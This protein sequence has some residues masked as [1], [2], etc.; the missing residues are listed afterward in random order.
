MNVLTVNNVSVSFVRQMQDKNLPDS[1]DIATKLFC[2]FYGKLVDA[3]PES[4]K[5]GH[6]DILGYHDA[7]NEAAVK[8]TA[9]AF[10]T[11]GRELTEEARRAVGEQFDY[12]SNLV[13]QQW[14]TVFRNKEERLV[15]KT[16]GMMVLLQRLNHSAIGVLNTLMD[17]LISRDINYADTWNS[18]DKDQ[19]DYTKYPLTVALKKI[20]HCDLP[21]A[22]SNLRKLEVA[23]LPRQM[24]SMTRKNDFVS[25]V[26][27]WPYLEGKKG[28]AGKHLV[29]REE[30]EW[31]AL[32]VGGPEFVQALYPY[33]AYTSEERALKRISGHLVA[34]NFLS[35]THKEE[36]EA[37]GAL[38]DKSVWEEGGSL[39]P[40]PQYS[41]FYQRPKD[42]K[43]TPAEKPSVILHYV[44]L[45]VAKLGM[46]KQRIEKEETGKILARI[47][48]HNAEVAAGAKLSSGE[49]GAI[50]T[51]TDDDDQ[52]INLK[53][54][55][56]RLS[57]VP[58]E[59]V[60]T[61]KPTLE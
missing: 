1:A 40:L 48:A 21:K 37:N 54:K 22:Q 18:W 33:G 41:R 45:A 49:A 42:K 36:I 7:S 47:E 52:Q 13:Q 56:R 32:C 4:A 25:Y 50:N 57:P 44:N 34:F 2:D 14:K 15:A 46:K 43:E 31:R 20:V 28:N 59:L 6:V 53:S 60:R 23:Y 17:I 58:P 39:N 5:G 8:L 55:K 12:H 27:L 3:L 38:S 26:T 30:Q 10:G 9:A 61:L 51:S 11:Q 24:V 35:F 19:H 16:E 29:Y